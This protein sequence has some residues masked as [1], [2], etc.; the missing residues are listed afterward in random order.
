LSV[1][2][3]AQHYGLGAGAFRKFLWIEYLRV[4]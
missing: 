3:S 1:A 4:V 2:C